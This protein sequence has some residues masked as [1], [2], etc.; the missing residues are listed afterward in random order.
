MARVQRPLKITIIMRHATVNRCWH[1][2]S[3]EK[4]FSVRT[5]NLIGNEVSGIHKENALDGG[6]VFDL[7]R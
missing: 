7:R 2:S 6:L 1:I 3:S 4:G 5:V